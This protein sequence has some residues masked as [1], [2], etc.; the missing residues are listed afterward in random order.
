MLRKNLW[1]L[2]IVWSPVWT[3]QERSC[4][5]DKQK[6]KVK[7]KQDEHSSNATRAH[8]FSKQLSV[9]LQPTRNHLKWPFSC[10]LWICNSPSGSGLLRLRSGK[11]SPVVCLE[12][13]VETT[14]HCL[15]QGSSRF[16]GRAPPPHMDAVGHVKVWDLNVSCYW[17]S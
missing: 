10:Q 8:N 2:G 3:I 13:K 9:C 1:G 7:A 4:L 12:S 6:N 15:F 11:Q 16:P 14:T 17:M 5:K